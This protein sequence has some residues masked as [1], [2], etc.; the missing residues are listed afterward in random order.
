[1]DLSFI[2]YQ[3]YSNQVL[4]KRIGIGV[5]SSLSLIGHTRC[6][7]LKNLLN[8]KLGKSQNHFNGLKTPLE[9]Q[10]DLT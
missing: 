8:E 9:K 7:H 6:T 1:M 3:V 10:N 2:E 4:Q 5:T